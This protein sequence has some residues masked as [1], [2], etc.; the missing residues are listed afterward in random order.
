LGG[1]SGADTNQLTDVVIEEIV[2][3]SEDVVPG[4]VTVQAFEE[5]P[6]AVNWSVRAIAL[7]ANVS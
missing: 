4:S 7:C 5:E 6:T 3:S 1:I 2:P